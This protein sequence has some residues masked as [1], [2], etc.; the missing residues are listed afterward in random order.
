MAASNGSAAAAALPRKRVANAGG[1]ALGDVLRAAHSQCSMR[2]HAGASGDTGPSRSAHANASPCTPKLRS[3]SGN[4]MSKA[5]KRTGA[6]P[7]AISTPASTMPAANVAVPAD[8]VIDGPLAPPA[9][10]QSPAG[11]LNTEL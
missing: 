11:A 8:T 1:K 7:L 9:L 5:I 4:V 2:P 6:P 10:V 3:D